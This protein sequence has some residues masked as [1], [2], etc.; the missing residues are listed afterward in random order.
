MGAETASLQTAEPA[1]HETPQAAIEHRYVALDAYRGIVMILL[2]SGGFGLAA[3][4]HH[5]TLGHFAERFGHVTWEGTVLWDLVQPAF[6][7]MV[8]VAMPFALARRHA[9]GDSFPQTL[10]HIAARSLRLILFSQILEYDH[11][12]TSLPT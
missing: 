3:L 4:A 5:P 8:G 1:S 10:R 11:T 9:R 6:M 2:A 12:E 7:F